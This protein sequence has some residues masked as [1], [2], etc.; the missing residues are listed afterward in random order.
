MPKLAEASKGVVTNFELRYFGVDDDLLRE[1]LVGSKG[2]DAGAAA[3]AA[4]AISRMGKTFSDE[5]LFSVME[6]CKVPG[7]GG[8]LYI[9][10]LTVDGS[11][12]RR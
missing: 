8:D 9:K 4:A 7:G 10:C 11:K 6:R 1:W 2:L 5:A 3:K 12:G